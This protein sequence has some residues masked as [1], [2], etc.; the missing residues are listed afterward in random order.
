MSF[1]YLEVI[2]LNFRFGKLTGFLL[3]FFCDVEGTFF[4]VSQYAFFGKDVVE[5]AGCHSLSLGVF[6]MVSDVFTLIL[7]FSLL[8]IF[9]ISPF[10]LLIYLNFV[11]LIQGF[12]SQV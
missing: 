10:G 12:L 7:R 2:I 6:K 3:K 9:F 4:Y 1:L 11:L 8:P 5:L